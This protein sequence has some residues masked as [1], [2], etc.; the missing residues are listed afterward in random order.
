MRLAIFFSLI[1]FGRAAAASD[2]ESAAAGWNCV[3][4][5]EIFN[6]FAECCRFTGDF[7]VENNTPRLIRRMAVRE[8][9][10]K[11]FSITV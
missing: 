6:P 9:T 7:C 8:K 5:V 3:Y 1:F 2:F 11:G 4:N 10:S